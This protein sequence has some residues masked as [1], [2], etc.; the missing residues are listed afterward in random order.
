MRRIALLVFVAGLS[1]ASIAHAQNRV[2]VR[3]FAEYF[4]LEGRLIPIL[5]G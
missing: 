3:A 5:Q 1:F 4:K 2:E